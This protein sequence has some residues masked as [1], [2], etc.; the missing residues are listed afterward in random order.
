LNFQ[1][2]LQKPQEGDRR[3]LPWHATDQK[4]MQKNAQHGG[5]FPVI[6]KEFICDRTFVF[7]TGI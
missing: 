3:G 7:L 1:I 5:R 6:T 4:Q 2:F